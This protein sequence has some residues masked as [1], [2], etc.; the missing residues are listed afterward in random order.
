MEDI[1][2][3]FVEGDYLSIFPKI[4]KNNIFIIKTDCFHKNHIIFFLNRKNKYMDI[5]LNLSFNQ[6]LNFIKEYNCILFVP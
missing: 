3:I 6:S 5:L 4:H 2:Y 1:F